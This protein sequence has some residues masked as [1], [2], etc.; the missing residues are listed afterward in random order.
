MRRTRVVVI[1]DA[2]SDVY[3]DF[4]YV[5]DCPDAPGVPVGVQMAHEVRP[6]GAANVAVNLAALA[7]S[8]VAVDLVSVMDSRLGSAVNSSSSGRVCLDWSVLTSS[9]E[10]LSKE[11]VSLGGR[12]VARLDSRREVPASAAEW[13]G[14]E[15]DRYLKAFPDVD[16]VVVSDYAGGV[17]TDSVMRALSPFPPPLVS[18]PVPPPPGSSSRRDTGRVRARTQGGHRL[19]EVSA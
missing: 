13:L 8:G 12:L 14:L 4:S 9:S 1:G 11:R 18:S 10:T 5:K 2:I 16:L 7:P 19:I 6:G 3:R 15:L 17:V